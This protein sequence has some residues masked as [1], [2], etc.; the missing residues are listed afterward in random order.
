MAT[1]T[2]PRQ[3]PL[4]PAYTD[5]LARYP[6]YAGTSALDDLRAAEY[7]R[8][9]HHGQVYLD[10]TGGSLHAESQLKQH[11]A[12]LH[13]G[14]FGNP[15]S[16]NPTSTATTH[17]VEG[18]RQYVLSYFHTSAED[19]VLVFTQNASGGLKLIGESFP[20]VPGSRFLLTFDNHNSVN[21]MREFARAKGAH[22]GYAPLLTPGLRLDMDRLEALLDQADPARENL[23]AY[24]AQSNF[25]GV[26]HPLDLI[27]R[28]QSKGW[29]VLLDAAAFVPT[30]RLDLQAVQPDFVAVSFYKMF[31]Y[32]TGVGA[33]LIRRPV[34]ARLQR[35]WFAGG[36]VNFASAQAQTH[37][38]APSEAAFEDG[39]LNYLAIP[40]VEIGL[41]HLQNIGMEMIAERVRCL[42]GWLLD[43]LVALR[44]TNGRAMVRVYGP[45]TT[46]A[47]GGTVT[48][49][50]Y[51]PEGHLL[52]YRRVEELAGEEGISLR[53]GCFCNPGAGESAEGLTAE[54]MQA[55]LT[56]GPDVNL[57]SFMRLMQNRGHKSAGAI[58]ASIGLV[59]N[60]ADVWR[61]L[62]FVAGFRDQTRLT[63]GEVS[64][65]I[66]SCRI[67]RDGS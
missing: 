41:R 30:N 35:P 45:T 61:F 38:L 32:P 39:T 55:A 13:S 8:L 52:D 26:K 23:F 56:L 27:A 47:R 18:T 53:T 21:G 60:F 63:I 36:T 59:S 43:E 64:F 29:R 67:I 6:G 33:V 57:L 40:A 42:T 14:I 12:L 50:L 48:L 19:Y 49:N 16:T 25:S 22:I 44:H 10:Y 66:E 4:Q 51:D 58:R 7:A 9:D 28:A 54:D 37:V 1:G 24:P 65:D 31:G 46:Q 62:N 20:F 5:F 17:H 34:F 11:L 15:H 2:A 3:T